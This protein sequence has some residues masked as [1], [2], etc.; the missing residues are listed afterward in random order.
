MNYYRIISIDALS[1][2]PIEGI[3]GGADSQRVSIDGMSVIVERES[4]FAVNSRWITHEQALAVVSGPDWA[5]GD[6]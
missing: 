6:I 1:R 3:R 5:S 4:G 2:I